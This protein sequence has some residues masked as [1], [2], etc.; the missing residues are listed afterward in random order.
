MGDLFGNGE[1]ARI[2]KLAFALASS[3]FTDCFSEGGFRAETSF[4][5]IAGT[6]TVSIQLRVP[7]E[8]DR[9]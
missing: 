1:F 6:R 2:D 3:A 8:I 9:S 4:L 7:D 5:T